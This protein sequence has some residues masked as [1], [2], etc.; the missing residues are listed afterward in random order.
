[1]RAYH[2]NPLMLQGILI[3]IGIYM[4]TCALCMETSCQAWPAYDCFLSDSG[5]VMGRL[6]I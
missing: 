6:R 3:G 1:M 2:K 5:D 4:N